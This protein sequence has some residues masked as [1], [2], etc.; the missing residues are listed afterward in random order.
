M[1]GTAKHSPSGGGVGVPLHSG[2]NRP[3]EVSK[4]HLLSD[5]PDGTIVPRVS[6]GCQP[7]ASP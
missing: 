4:I 6:I 3:Q 1:L 5:Q 2:S 7:P